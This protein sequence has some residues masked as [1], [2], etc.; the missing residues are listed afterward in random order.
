MKKRIQKTQQK[1][2][3]LF[4][5]Y[6]LG[7]LSLS[8]LILFVIFKIEQKYNNRNI[9][10]TE[11]Q[12]IDY[13]DD[14]AVQESQIVYSDLFINTRDENLV[15]YVNTMSIEDL[16]SVAS[17]LATFS[18]GRARYDQIR[19]INNDGLETLRINYDGEKAT[20]VAR[21]SLQNKYTRYYFQNIIALN[22]G[23]VF[24]SPLD[25]NIENGIV[26]NPRKPVIRVGTPIFDSADNKQGIFIY[27][28]L[29]QIF[30]DKLKANY[31]Q[32]SGTFYILNEDGYWIVGPTPK[33]EYGFMFED[34]KTQTFQ[35]TYPEIWPLIQEKQSGQVT[36]KQGVFTFRIIQPIEDQAFKLIALSFVPKK[37]LNAHAYTLIQNLAIIEA[38]IILLGILLAQLLAYNVVARRRAEMQIINLNE[39]LKIT[40]ETLRHDLRNSLS[41]IKLSLEIFVKEN[42]KAMLRIAKESTQGGIDLIESMKQLEQLTGQKD[43][44]QLTNVRTLLN[45][46]R[47]EYNIPIIIKGDAVVLAD[48][49][50]VSVF[51]NLIRNAITH[52]KTKK[53][54]I[55]IKETQ[56]QTEIRVIDF[57]RGIPV[58]IQDK[59][60][61]EGFTYG[62]TSQSGLGLYIVRKTIERY[63]GTITVKDTKPKGATFV[64]KL[65]VTQ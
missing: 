19:I 45:K 59:L 28:Y 24:I 53:I 9:L 55:S 35:N 50:L 49:A 10:A 11:S 44:L 41:A 63:N 16:D 21:E 42:D 56:N 64:I 62:P 31:Y 14:V 29:A 32:G 18:N 33:E 61:T 2:F 48:H 43:A 38:A 22:E 34:K 13:M 54:V 26:E 12:L 27:N 3:P 47:K 6:F 40:N 57:G 36:T 37:T 23:E 52:G 30:I 7:L 39:I 51:D 8:M 20:R 5:G 46:K 60:F 65:P 15:N 1:V 25:L 17:D 58:K 4:M